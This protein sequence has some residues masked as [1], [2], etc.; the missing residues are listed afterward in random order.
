MMHLSTPI[1]VNKGCITQWALSLNKAD[2]QTDTVGVCMKEREKDTQNGQ[3]YE[4]SEN[5]LV[6][7]Q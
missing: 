5:V 4:A 2:R 3:T 1:R 7:A 6:K